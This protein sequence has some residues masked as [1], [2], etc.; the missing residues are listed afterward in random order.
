MNY[1]S[2]YQN[3]V[4]N[5]VAIIMDGN[6]RWATSR[7]LPRT[8]GHRQG[9]KAVKRTVRAAGE[10]G[11]KY[12]TLFGFSAENW[13]RPKG[14]VNELMR[15]LRYY[16][17]SETAELLKN[18]L[19]LRILGDVTAFDPDIQDLIRNAESM[20]Q[21]N[22]GMTVSIAL[23]Y[24]GRQDILNAVRKLAGFGSLESLDDDELQSMFESN[25]MTKGLPD[26][27]LLIRTSGEERISNFLLWQCAYSEFFF[28]ETLWPDFDKIDLEQAIAVYHSRERR[29][30]GIKASKVQ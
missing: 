17:R 8:I 3:Q 22:T 11:I 6:G 30:G 2:D 7:G 5:H 20:S 4:P 21:K 24:G 27:D 26:P 9:A 18:N 25:L 10:L 16:L 13:S 23:N 29:F 12:L 28:T 15:L 1:K 19:K 14:E